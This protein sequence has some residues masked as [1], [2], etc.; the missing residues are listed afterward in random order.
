VKATST[1]TGII[2]GSGTIGAAVTQ[3]VMPYF[4]S[5]TFIFYTGR[6]KFDNREVKL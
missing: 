4:Q 6:N 5:G 3:L 1:I 2:D